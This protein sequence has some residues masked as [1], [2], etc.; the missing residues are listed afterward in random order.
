MSALIRPEQGCIIVAVLASTIAGVSTA[1]SAEA[2]TPPCAAQQQAAVAHLYLEAHTDRGLAGDI[3]FAP[4]SYRT[5]NG[6][7]VDGREIEGASQTGLTTITDERVHSWTQNTDARTVRVQY[8]ADYALRTPAAPVPLT[9]AAVDETFAF[10]S[11]CQIQRIDIVITPRPP[12][13]AG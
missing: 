7:R 10:N 1:T 5:I 8:D 6:I 13:P 2:E 9:T 11:A 3:P 12:G 4:D